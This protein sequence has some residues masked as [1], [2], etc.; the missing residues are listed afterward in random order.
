[1]KLAPNLRGTLW[2]ILAGW[3]GSSGCTHNYYYGAVPACGPTGLPVSGQ[4]GQICE[5]P[6]GQVVVSGAPSSEVGPGSGVVVQAPSQ[7]SAVATNTQP[8]VLISQPAYG[9]SISQSI[10]RLKW[11]RPDPESL[12]TTR[13]EGALDSGSVRQ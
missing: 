13:V 7:G 12:A 5:V 11:R 3:V 6:S 8:R 10:N 4:V 1:V 2:I 9:P